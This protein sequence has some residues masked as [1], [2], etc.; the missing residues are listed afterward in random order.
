MDYLNPIQVQD[1]V[2]GLG[3]KIFTVEFDKSNGETRKMNCRRGVKKHLK[4]GESSLRDCPHLMTV[5]DLVKRDYRCFNLN[6]VRRLRAA[7]RT[8]QP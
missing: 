3:S 8:F 4:G 6:T 1:V 5:F 7:G 2:R